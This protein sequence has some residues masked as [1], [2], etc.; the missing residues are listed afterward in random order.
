MFKNYNKFFSLRG[1]ITKNWQHWNFLLEI[2]KSSNK[3]I[4]N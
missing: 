1:A 3:E 4:L 2:F